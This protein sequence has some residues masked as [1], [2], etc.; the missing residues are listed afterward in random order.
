M[1][2]PPSLGDLIG[3]ELVARTVEIRGTLPHASGLET[4][5]RVF[6]GAADWLHDRAAHPVVIS[7]HG[8]P[9]F[10]SNYMM[11]L[12]LLVASG[13]VVVQ[14]DQCG[15]GHSS[16]VA[17]PHTTN[18]ELL[19]VD[20]YVA[21]LAALV[22]HL[23]VDDRFYIYGSS[24]GSMLAQEFA[25]RARLPGLAGMVLDGALADAQFYFQTQWRDVLVPNVP[26][27][28]MARLRALEAAKAYESPE[29]KQIEE[30]LSGQF[31]L[32]LVPRPACWFDSLAG[33][34]SAIYVAMQGASEFTVGGVLEHWSVLEQNRRT[35][36][37]AL[38]LAGEFDTMSIACQQQVVDSLPHAWPLVVIPRAAHCKLID[39]PHACC[40]QVVKFISTIE[41]TRRTP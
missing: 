28:T 15:C 23:G 32:R 4:A 30:W 40:A 7:L 27:F 12:N 11:P 14:Y 29:Y 2:T 18:P 16:R 24:W 35:L 34:N 19:T 6:T 25:G 20:F 9:A 8:G 13:M 1:T 31:T 3:H 33:S 10:T 17:E 41:H 22:R 39:E 26:A 37:P 38:V 21:E 5:Y 36:T